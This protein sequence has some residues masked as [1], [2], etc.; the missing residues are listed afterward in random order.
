[1]P[2]SQVQLGADG[3][4]TGVDLLDDGVGERITG[5]QCPLDERGPALAEPRHDGGTGA[6]ARRP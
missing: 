1:V 3:R 6:A 5:A 2:D 4:S